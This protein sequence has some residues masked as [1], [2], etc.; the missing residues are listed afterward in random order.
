MTKQQNESEQN[1]WRVAIAMP[2]SEK[3][4]MELTV[5]ILIYYRNIMRELIENNV[6]SLES[7]EWQQKPRFY[8]KGT[9]ETDLKVIVKVS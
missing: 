7:I 8:L 3:E 5:K 4:K 1:N 6:T 9:S 2:S